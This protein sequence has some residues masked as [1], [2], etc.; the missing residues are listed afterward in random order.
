M[1]LG[2]VEKSR[3]IWSHAKHAN[4][5]YY[6]LVTIF[7]GLISS[8][9]LGAL[10]CKVVYGVSFFS[11][12][13]QVFDPSNTSLISA[14]KAMQF[15]NS[16]GTF[17]VPPILFLHLRGIHFSNYTQLS[18]GFDF[19][20]SIT[21]V[22]IALFIIPLANF[23]GAINALVPLPEFLDFLKTAE[24]QTTLVTEQFLIMPHWS[25]L[26]LMLIL[27]GLVAGIG[28]ELLFRGVLQ[29]LFKDWSGSIHLSVWLTAFLFS[30]IHLQYHAILPRFVLGALIG[31][32]Y[33]YSGNLNYSI[34]LH[35]VYNSILVVF[36]YYIQH[37][38]LDTSL[39]SIGVQD[40]PIV[41]VALIIVF[42]MLRIFMKK[43]Y[44]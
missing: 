29:N 18:K 33:V 23:M 9:I 30:V 8:Y 19:N 41:I 4:L 5:L 34:L 13:Q 39:E 28:E 17:F 21:I 27:M 16:V 37:N 25:D 14:M 10:Y 36:T 24:A 22:I 3:G 11:S 42:M 2:I 40:F 15:F 35:V 26:L 32:V 12:S 38:E 44:I 1:A 7:V 43:R 20:K 6:L 31:Y